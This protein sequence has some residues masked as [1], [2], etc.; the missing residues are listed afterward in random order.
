MQRCTPLLRWSEHQD[1]L[2]NISLD[3]EDNLSS[4]QVEDAISN[5][6]LKIKKMFPEIRRIFIEAQALRAHRRDF[7]RQEDSTK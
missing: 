4:S 3:F 2:L 1:I 7:Q 6:E 5:F